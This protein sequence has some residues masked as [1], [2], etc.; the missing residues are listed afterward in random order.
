[1]PL[2]IYS[3]HYVRETRDVGSRVTCPIVKHNVCGKCGKTGHFKGSCKV[4][5][6]K[7]STPIKV[8]KVAA[9]KTT[10]KFDFPSDSEDEADDEADEAEDEVD[11]YSKEF[12]ALESNEPIKICKRK[13]IYEDEGTIAGWQEEF[14][15]I[16]SLPEDQRKNGRVY[17]DKEH[18][19]LV[20]KKYEIINM[21]DVMF[22]RYTPSWASEDEYEDEE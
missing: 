9:V 7:K 14:A 15:H 22:L 2:E 13:R 18:G 11:E 10:N 19:K 1:M 3:S 12:P 6:Q 20:K 17:W 4:S 5:Q 8:V 21:N 16:L